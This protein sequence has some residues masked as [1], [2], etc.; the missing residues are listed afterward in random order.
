MTG[1]VAS[2][3]RLS[4]VT[5]AAR[6]LKAFSPGH[7]DWGVADLSKHLSISTS[8]VHRLLSTLADEGLLEQDPRTGRYRLGLSVFDLVGALPTQRSLHEAVLVSMTEL[9]SRTGETV[10]VGVLDGRQVVYVERLDSP[11][12]L[13]MFAELGRRNDA[14]CTSSGKVLLAFAPRVQLD[15]ILRGW[16]LPRV[17]RHTITDPR[18]LRSELG[19]IRRQGYAENREESEPGIVSIAAPIRDESAAVIASLSVAG[20]TERIDPER[21]A[22]AEAVVTLARRVS[23]QMG[24]KAG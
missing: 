13:R 15:R 12:T 3:N 18:V 4:S 20:P 5:N 22:I 9:R 7:P 19:T 11:S 17:T 6:V 8:S 1:S 21:L 14:H 2:R 23:R 24:W 16:T 10:Q